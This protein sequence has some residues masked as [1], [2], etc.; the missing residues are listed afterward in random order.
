MGR[1][2]LSR[3]QRDL[4]GP[5]G[6]RALQLLRSR[7]FQRESW[8]AP[9]KSSPCSLKPDGRLTQ[10]DLAGL[11]LPREYGTRTQGPRLTWVLL[12]KKPSAL[13]RSQALPIAII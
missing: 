10:K 5:R 12:R 3:R 7:N 8:K 6:T 9:P 4:V 11:P 13:S 1:K 2:P